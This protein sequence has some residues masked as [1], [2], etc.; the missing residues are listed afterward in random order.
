MWI[1][2]DNL[3]IINVGTDIIV[4]IVGISH[5]HPDISVV[6]SRLE[7][8]IL[9]EISKQGPASFS[10]SCETVQCFDNN[11][12]ALVTVAKLNSASGKHLFLSERLDKCISNVTTENF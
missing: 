1:F 4:A 2:C 6:T 7:A 10:T 5:A 3:E 9:K 8:K 11:S 12:N